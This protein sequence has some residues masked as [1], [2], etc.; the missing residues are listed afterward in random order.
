LAALEK[1]LDAVSEWIYRDRGIGS[2][3]HPLE[4]Y[5]PVLEKMLREA[6]GEPEPVEDYTDDD[7]GADDERNT[8]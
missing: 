5:I 4:K 1:A 7:A 8:L 3:I 2:S 6:K